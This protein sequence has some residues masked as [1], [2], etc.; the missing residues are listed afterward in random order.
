MK[1]VAAAL[2]TLLLLA[3]YPGARRADGDVPSDQ[4]PMYGNVETPHS[5]RVAHERFIRESTTAFGSREAA[6]DAF[7][8]G[9]WQLYEQDDLA[10]AMSRFNAAWLLNP[11]S[12]QP[13]W[14]FGAI[15]Q[16][17]RHPARPGTGPRGTRHAEPCP[18][19][20]SVK[21]AAHG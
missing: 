17:W 15:L 9:G 8:R 16:I 18:G 7:A 19:P 12:P 20:R 1:R 4:I 3:G 2:L 6:S 5:L 14:G 11:Q 13:Y 21:S 10:A